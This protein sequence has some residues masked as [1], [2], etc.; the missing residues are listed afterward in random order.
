MG[1]STESGYFPVVAPENL[2]V[3]RR[4]YEALARGDIEA[5]LQLIHPEVEWHSLVLEVE[6]TL[7]G[8]EGVRQWWESLRTV[9]P[10]W[11]PELTDV[12]DHGDWVLAH[13]R[14]SARG[15]AS[16]VGTGGDF[17]QAWKFR[18]GLMARL[19]V[20]RTRDEALGIIERSQ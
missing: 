1:S 5:F 4:A 10:D 13:A 12:E 17:W 20:V 14:S 6:G 18:D 8:H 16:G 11:R 3:A 2:E 9:F 19:H 15:A 7:H